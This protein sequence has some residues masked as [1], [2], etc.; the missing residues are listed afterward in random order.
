MP[1]LEGVLN[2]ATRVPKHCLF[3]PP[4]ASSSAGDPE[5]SRIVMGGC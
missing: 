4:V 2:E 5:Q 1:S 3:L